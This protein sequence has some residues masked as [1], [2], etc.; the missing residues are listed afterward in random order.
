MNLETD[1]VNDFCNNVPNQ[2]KATCVENTITRLIEVDW[3]N[4]EKAVAF[5]TNTDSSFIIDACYTQLVYESTFALIPG[6]KEFFSLCEALPSQ[7]KVQCLAK[8]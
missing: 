1:R 7:Y 5:C 4:I 8:I 3:D 6:S 2:L